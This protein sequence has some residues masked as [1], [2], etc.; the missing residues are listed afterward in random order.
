[1]NNDGQNLNG[2]IIIY[3]EI[4]KFSLY[5]KRSPENQHH[6]NINMIGH[7]NHQT[8][9]ETEITTLYIYIDAY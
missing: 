7:T 5:S 9:R 3:S 8:D 1:M 6:I 4:K 2:T